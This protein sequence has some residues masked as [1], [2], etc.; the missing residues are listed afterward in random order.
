MED[1][2]IRFKSQIDTIRRL[3]LAL[4]RIWDSHRE[5]VESLDRIM[6]NEFTKHKDAFE[7]QRGVREQGLE[8]QVKKLSQ[9]TTEEQLTQT[10]NN[11]E[12]VIKMIKNY[13]KDYEKLQIEKLSQYKPKYAR[14]AN[15]YCKD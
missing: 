4:A 7:H 3:M 5:K 1:S 2:S 11:I 9:Q 14:E 10:L 6:K 15:V 13:F 8:S 12:N